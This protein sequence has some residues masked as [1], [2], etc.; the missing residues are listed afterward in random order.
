MTPPMKMIAQSSGV[1]ENSGALLCMK[2]RQGMERIIW[3]IACAA[4]TLLHGIFAI[5]PRILGVVR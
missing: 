4:H 3:P 2:I 1:A 5:V